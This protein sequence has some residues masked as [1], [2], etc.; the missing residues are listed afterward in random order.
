MF[1]SC[2]IL[3]AFAYGF[4]HVGREARTKLIP[5]LRKWNE[6]VR[7]LLVY[8][9][10]IGTAGCSL[11]VTNAG[12][13]KYVPF[14]AVIIQ[15]AGERRNNSPFVLLAANKATMFGDAAV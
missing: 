11:I 12:P 2:K 4:F 3:V 13:R 14:L 9:K 7:G 8:M 10:R 15:I 1:V 5:G 6:V